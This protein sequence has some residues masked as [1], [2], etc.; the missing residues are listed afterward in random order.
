MKKHL[1]ALAAALTVV[2]G[3]LA[4][5]AADDTQAQP[6]CKHC[7]MDRAK[8]AHSRML[9][10]Y[11]DGS[12][13]ATCSLHC[14]AVQLAEEL[15]HDVKTL[16][17]GDYGTKQ[18]VDAEKAYWVIGGKLPGVMTRNAKWAFEKKEDAEK[19]VAAQG[20]A[21]ATFEQAME[22]AYQDMYKDTKMI[23]EK[24]KMRKKESTGHKAH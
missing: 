5:P 4:A 14:T 1:L 16:K 6:S 13:V 17:V 19:F 18:L 21:P 3:A 15:D 24:R 23:R 7:G 20:G 22:A 9:V 12:A 8:F 11:E 10:E 2:L